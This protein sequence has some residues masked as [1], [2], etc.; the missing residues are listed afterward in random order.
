MGTAKLVWEVG[1]L[2]DVSSCSLQTVW[3]QQQMF[4]NRPTPLKGSHRRRMDEPNFMAGRAVMPYLIFFVV[5]IFSYS[6]FLL[7]FR[8]WYFNKIYT[9]LALWTRL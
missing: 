4:R 3:Q 7:S 5:I 1:L 9:E 6:V 2:F 8:I